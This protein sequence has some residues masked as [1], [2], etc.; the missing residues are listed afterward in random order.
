M[1]EKKPVSVNWQT[2]FIVIPVI[3][4]WASYRIE[5]LRLY[6]LVIIAMIVVE[7]LGAA[8]IFPENFEDY[9]LSEEVS[10]EHLVFSAV[11]ILVEIVISIVLIRKWTKEWNQQI[12]SEN[13]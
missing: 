7:F 3:D 9:Y 10:E 5:K 4:L 11:V 1:V 6:L 13:S 8:W 12:K 2:L